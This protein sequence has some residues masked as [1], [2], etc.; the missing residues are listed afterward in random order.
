MYGRMRL[1]VAGQSAAQFSTNGDLIRWPI[2][3]EYDSWPTG[4]GLLGVG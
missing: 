2:L 1:T 4:Y 3:A